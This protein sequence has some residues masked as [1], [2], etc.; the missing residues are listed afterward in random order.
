M[1]SGDMSVDLAGKRSDVDPYRIR[2]R[3]RHIALVGKVEL[4]LDHCA[5]VDDPRKYYGMASAFVDVNNDGLV[6]LVVTNDSAP[7]Y[8]Y[9]NKGNGRFEDFS[10][11]SGTAVNEAGN[12]GFLNLATGQI[13]PQSIKNLTHLLWGEDQPAIFHLYSSFAQ[14]ACPACGVGPTTRSIP[15]R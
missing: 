1:K 13:R 3:A 11:P 6:D 12:G 4:R 10:Y 14:S 7:N 15:A 9:L 5:G 2:N 8:L